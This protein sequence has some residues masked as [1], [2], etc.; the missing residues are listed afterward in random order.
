MC[1]EFCHFQPRRVALHVARRERLSAP[2]FALLSNQKMCC[3]TPRGNPNAAREPR[4]E[5]RVGVELGRREAEFRRCFGTWPPASPA[6]RPAS[7]T[8]VARLGGC[9]S[10]LRSRASAG[11][12]TDAVET[13]KFA[14]VGARA[15]ASNA[16]RNKRQ[17]SPRRSKKSD[18]YC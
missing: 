9:V 4:T 17:D 8:R 1:R 2:A 10:T 12:V 6:L 16:V 15:R 11:H 7:S 14:C 18:G 13:V 3:R 5:G